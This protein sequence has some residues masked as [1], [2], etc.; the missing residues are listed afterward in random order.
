VS[1][2]AL[3]VPNAVAQAV[4]DEARAALGAIVV[5]VSKLEPDLT[6]TGLAWSVEPGARYQRALFAARKIM[7]G[8][9]PVTL[10]VDANVNPY[11]G[12]VHLMGRTMLARFEEAARYTVHPMVAGFASKILEMRWTLSIPMRVGV[13]I[14]GSFSA[15]FAQ[16]PSDEQRRAAASFAERAAAEIDRSGAFQ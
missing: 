2:T 10:I 6:I 11:I 4:A 5:N 13:R 7:P 8:L 12:E 16:L 3:S 9:D 1:A 15:H 14:V